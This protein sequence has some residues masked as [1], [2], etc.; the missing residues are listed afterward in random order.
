MNWQSEDSLDGRY[1][2]PLPASTIVGRADPSGRGRRIDHA[3]VIRRLD[4]AALASP[5][6]PPFRPCRSIAGTPPDRYR[7]RHAFR[8]ASAWPSSR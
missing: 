2:G 1:F 7:R 5:S 3:D 8:R 4:P 6:L